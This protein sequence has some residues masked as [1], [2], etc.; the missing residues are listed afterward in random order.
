MPDK[1][2]VVIGGGEEYDNITKIAQDNIKVLGY[3]SDEVLISTMQKAKG[4]VY[5]AI[6]DFGIIPIEA[7][8]CGTPVIALNEGGTKETVI[9]KITGIHFK[10]QTQ[11]SIIDAITEFEQLYFDYKDIRKEAIKY[12]YFEKE[13]LAFITKNY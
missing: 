11:E 9:S 13:L 1:K 12:T 5:A 10:K 2:L 8:A 4:F 7:M 6:E 3:Q